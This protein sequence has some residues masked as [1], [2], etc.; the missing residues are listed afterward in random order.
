M[1]HHNSSVA[2]IH[3]HGAY[4][5]NTSNTKDGFSS[6]GNSLDPN[7]T[8]TSESDRFGVNYYVVT[9]AGNLYRYDSNSGN[10]AGT[11]LRSDMPVDSRID[12]HQ[13]M[14]NTLL[15]NL[16]LIN[17]P[18]GTPQDYVNARRNNPTSLLD[19]IHALEGFR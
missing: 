10:Y 3:T 8:D 16:L 1:D 13:S 2:I 14:Q 12:I 17:F 18:N 9:P 19:T 5:A 4:D 11:L 15:W 7:Y 6:P